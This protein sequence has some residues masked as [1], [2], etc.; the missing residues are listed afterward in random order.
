MGDQ[1]LENSINLPNE[2][3]E[4]HVARQHQENSL[5]AEIAAYP[6]SPNVLDS[7]LREDSLPI[8]RIRRTEQLEDVALPHIFNLLLQYAVTPNLP[9]SAQHLRDNL[10]ALIYNENIPWPNH[11]VFPSVFPNLERAALQEIRY[12]IRRLNREQHAS[13]AIPRDKAPNTPKWILALF[14]RQVPPGQ[15]NAEDKPVCAICIQ[16]LPARVS[17]A[18]PCNHWFCSPCLDEWI[19]CCEEVGREVNCPICFVGIA[20]IRNNGVLGHRVGGFLGWN[21]ERVV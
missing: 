9:I 17:I 20:R 7:P 13:V 18:R 11:L 3:P 21:F 2:P 12:H 19:R 16:E 10:W 15:R 6:P 8:S 1:Q 14:P 5:A 4:I